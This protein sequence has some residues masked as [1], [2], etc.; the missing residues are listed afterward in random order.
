MKGRAQKALPLFAAMFA[1]ALVSAPELAAQ[2]PW[3]TPLTTLRDALTGPTA[4][5]LAALGFFI[6]GGALVFMGLE[7]GAKKFAGAALGLSVMLGAVNLVDL[8]A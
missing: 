4:R 6:A 7:G 8:M 3:D 1:L 5:L 2:M